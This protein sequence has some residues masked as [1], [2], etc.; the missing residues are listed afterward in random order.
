MKYLITI[1]VS[2]IFLITF[3]T[4]SFA[5]D[6]VS[7]KSE[8]NIISEIKLDTSYLV[9][10]QNL[11]TEA[12]SPEQNL[13]FTIGILLSIIPSFG[14]GNFWS[15]D[16]EGGWFFFKLD[17]IMLAIPF[18]ISII[19]NIFYS[20]NISKSSSDT[21]NN[22]PDIFTLLGLVAWSSSFGVKIWE[23]AS[24]YKYISEEKKIEKVSISKDQISIKLLD[25]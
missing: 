25:F 14:V 10:N 7:L 4:K 3:N 19:S 16:K 21:M 6:S 8:N 5:S 23:T 2:I 15:G 13:D 20:L 24:V 17:L 9:S 18:I 11:V 1:I 22:S 12:F